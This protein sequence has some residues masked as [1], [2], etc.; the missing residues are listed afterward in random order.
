M[1]TPLCR[2]DY[3][4]LAQIAREAIV[5]CVAKSTEEAEFLT[6]D[7]L[8][9]LNK[10]IMAGMPGYSMK[11]VLD[12]QDVGFVVVKEYWNLSHLFVLPAYQRR[13]IGRTLLDGAI[14]A[15]RDVCP[16]PEIQLNSSHFAADFYRNHGF[17][18]RGPELDRP[19]GCIPL[20]LRYQERKS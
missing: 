8:D 1:Q 12:G 4:P 2:A 10:W 5:D 14:S 19:G 7:V 9:S 13:G 17:T 15:C 16:R 3:E 20:E 11:F 6:A 18:A